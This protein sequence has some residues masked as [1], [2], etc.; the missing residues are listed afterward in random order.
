MSC[1][2]YGG[3][4][5]NGSGGPSFAH[6]ARREGHLVSNHSKAS[7]APIL[8]LSEEH[9]PKV[10][11]PAIVV[12]MVAS[13][14]R[15][16]WRKNT[17]AVHPVCLFPGHL[18]RRIKKVIIKNDNLFGVKFQYQTQ[19]PNSRL[20]AVLLRRPSPRPRR[21]EFAAWVDADATLILPTPVYPHDKRV[22]SEDGE[23]PS[24]VTDGRTTN[25]VGLTYASND[26][27]Y[28]SR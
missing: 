25:N 9:R 11:V 7:L 27:S 1:Q 13:K 21:G 22:A 16:L 15:K 24:S 4:V 26:I 20:Y 8:A 6:G 23:P 18:G 10:F 28:P 17:H 2:I 12:M 19:R 3:T 14:S 5:S